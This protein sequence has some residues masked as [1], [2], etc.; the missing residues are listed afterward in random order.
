VETFL[1]IHPLTVRQSKI[2]KL[3]EDCNKYYY[4]YFEREEKN[5]NT[6]TEI[7]CGNSL[8]SSLSHYEV[9]SEIDERRGY[10][11]YFHDIIEYIIEKNKFIKDL[12]SENKQHLKNLLYTVCSSENIKYLYYKISLRE[13]MEWFFNSFYE[14]ANKRYDE[15]EDLE[16]KS[17]DSIKS[18]VF[19]FFFF[20]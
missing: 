17:N 16:L 7:K 2:N 20:E 3:K 12:N 9:D 8:P 15:C 1:N 14:E 18:Q 19:I 13:E 6:T 11:Q 5:N 4:S 10:E